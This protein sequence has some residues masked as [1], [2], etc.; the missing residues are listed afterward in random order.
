MA[1]MLYQIHRQDLGTGKTEMVAQN[2]F[3][4]DQ[5]IPSPLD[6]ALEAQDRFQKWQDDVRSRHELPEGSRWLVV[7]E[8]SRFFVWAAEKQE[9]C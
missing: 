8:K 6:A 2:E 5:S 7:N 9:T 1:V 4:P 3:P